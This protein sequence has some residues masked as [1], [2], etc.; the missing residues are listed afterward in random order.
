MIAFLSLGDFSM[1]ENYDGHDKYSCWIVFLV[2][3]FWLNLL[4]MNFIITLMGGPY[5]TV[6]EGQV[7]IEY[8]QRLEI[9]YENIEMV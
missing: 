1:Y 9:I 2:C 3:V 8:K 4:L 7:M 5:E 6:L